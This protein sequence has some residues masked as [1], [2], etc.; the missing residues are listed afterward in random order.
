MPRAKASASP[1]VMAA[2]FSARVPSS[3][4]STAGWMIPFITGV[5]SYERVTGSSIAPVCWASRA[6][7]AGI[8]AVA[9][10][11]ETSTPEAERSRSATR[12]IRPPA[13]SRRARVPKAAPPLCGRTSMP[14]PSR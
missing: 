8:R 5:L 11:N 3:G 14:R 6:G 10:K 13:R 2:V 1:W 4:S 7:P 12:Q 9:P